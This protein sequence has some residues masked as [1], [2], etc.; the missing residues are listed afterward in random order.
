[1]NESAIEKAATEFL[2]D[3]KGGQFKE[4][5]IKVGTIIRFILGIKY[6]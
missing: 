6:S 2:T 4:A 1:M 5:G 3:F